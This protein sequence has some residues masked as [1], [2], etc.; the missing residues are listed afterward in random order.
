MR[1]FFDLVDSAYTVHD[2][3]GVEVE[4]G[5]DGIEIRQAIAHEV[6]ELMREFSAED[7]RGWQLRVKDD[8]GRVL[9]TIPLDTG[10]L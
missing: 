6:A 8:A 1:I 5:E 4:D 7:R 2:K 3:D 9:F 10:V